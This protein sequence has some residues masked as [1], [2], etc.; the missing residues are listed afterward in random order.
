MKTMKA[1]CTAIVLSLTISISAFAGDIATPGAACTGTTSTS[2][3]ISTDPSALPTDTAEV[4]DLDTG[5]LGDILLT[6]VLM[7]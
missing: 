7:F 6:L 3:A 1:F 4:G 2:G 5:A